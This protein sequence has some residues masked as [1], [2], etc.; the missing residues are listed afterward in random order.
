MAVGWKCWN[1][2]SVINSLSE[3]AQEGK[4]CTFGEIRISAKTG[5]AMLN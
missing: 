3:S 2:T 1:E 5:N 4:V